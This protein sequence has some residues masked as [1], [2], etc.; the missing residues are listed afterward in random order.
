MKIIYFEPG[1]TNFFE[2]LGDSSRLEGPRLELDLKQRGPQASV[3]ITDVIVLISQDQI[4]TGIIGSAI[5]DIIKSIW[6][7]V[8]NHTFKYL[9]R[10]EIK[11]RKGNIKLVLKVNSDKELEFELS[12][13]VQ[14]ELVPAVM[15]KLSQFTCNDMQA[16]LK[17]EED[18]ALDDLKRKTYRVKYDQVNK[19]WI[20]IQLSEWERQSR[21]LRRE[22][23]R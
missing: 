7:K 16:V 15:D 2:E 3:S 17:N 21:K 6:I 5:W 18:Y 20:A 14:Q 12:G 22:S 13:E 9:Q 4:A 1:L 11:N 10:G 19:V 8:V 23:R